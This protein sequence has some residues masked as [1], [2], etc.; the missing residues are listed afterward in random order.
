MPQKA[1]GCRTDPPV[2]DPRA[3]GTMRA[4]TA[5]ADPPD[6]P[7]G[8]RVV[9]HGFRVGPKAECSVDDPIANSSRLVLPTT[10]HPRLRRRAT[11]VASNGEMNFGRMREPHVVRMSLVTMLSLTASGAPA[12]SPAT[13]MKAFNCGFRAAI[14]RSEASTYSVG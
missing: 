8:T 12:P 9:S 14:A 2:S 1:A 4:A 6:E 11:A 13:C 3:A 7:P 10:V 5:A